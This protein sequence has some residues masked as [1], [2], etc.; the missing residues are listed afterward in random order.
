MKN[1]FI[2]FFKETNGGFHAM[3]RINRLPNFN[4]PHV[5]V[6]RAGRVMTLADCLKYAKKYIKQRRDRY[7]KYTYIIE[8]YKYVN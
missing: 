6:L 7:P 8:E 1:E 2:I 3:C 5:G 4:Y